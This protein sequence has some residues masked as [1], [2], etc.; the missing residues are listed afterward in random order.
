MLKHSEVQFS[1]TISLVIFQFIQSV[2]FELL[3][4]LN[5]CFK[6]SSVCSRKLYLR[7]TINLELLESREG[8]KLI[9]TPFMSMY[10]KARLDYSNYGTVFIL[11]FYVIY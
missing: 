8:Q 1:E 11:N 9:K 2:G 6:Y 5:T 3:K 7:L 10:D 4:T